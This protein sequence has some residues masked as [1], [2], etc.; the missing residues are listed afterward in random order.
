[1]IPANLTRLPVPKRPPDSDPPV[2]KI[3]IPINGAPL[4]M[5]LQSEH[6]EKPVLLFLHGGPGMPE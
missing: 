4:T 3:H 5:F 1:M 6:P 2:Q